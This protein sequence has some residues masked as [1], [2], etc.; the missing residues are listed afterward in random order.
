MQGLFSHAG[1]SECWRKCSCAAGRRQLTCWH[2]SCEQDHLLKLQ[3]QLL[4]QLHQQLGQLLLAWSQTLR[5]ES[6]CP[7]EW[8]VDQRSWVKAML[9]SV[10][11]KCAESLLDCIAI[12]QV[13]ILPHNSTT[14]VPCAVSHSTCSSATC[15]QICRQ[16]FRCLWALEESRMDAIQLQPSP[17]CSCLIA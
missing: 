12:P 15:L 1:I 8:M 17:Y 7:L 3:R 16:Y 6:V 10:A 4:V 9:V 11:R 14:V 2:P 5:W 13:C